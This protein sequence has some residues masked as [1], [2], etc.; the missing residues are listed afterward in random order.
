MIRMHA[1]ESKM[2]MSRCRIHV[3][4]PKLLFTECIR[5]SCWLA[6]KHDEW[7]TKRTHSWLN[8]TANWFKRMLFRSQKVSSK[9]VTDKNHVLHV[10]TLE[11][12]KTHWKPNY[13]QWILNVFNLPNGFELRA[14][15]DEKWNKA[16][17]F[18]DVGQSCNPV[19]ISWSTKHK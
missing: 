16:K 6:T 1:K 18:W 12:W 5:I 2:Q 15:S 3:V 11:A 7:A 9:Q 4:E 19:D 17:L 8:S 14:I 10:V 13:F